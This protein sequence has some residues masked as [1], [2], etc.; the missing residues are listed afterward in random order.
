MCSTL[1][2][3]STMTVRRGA[4]QQG[5]A[6]ESALTPTGDSNLHLYS[7]IFSG[8]PMGVVVLH[9]E[10]PED[11][12]SFRIVS[13]NPA[14]ASLTGCSLDKV[15]G[16]TLGEFP[17]LLKTALPRACMNVLH[18]RHPRNLGEISYGDERIHQG[19]YSVQIF[20]LYE[21]FLAVAFENITVRRQ[22]EQ[23]LIESEERFRLLVQSVQE[24]AIFQLDP[25][26]QI[27]SWNSGAERLKG[28]RAEEV[29]GKQVSLFYPPEDVQSGKPA[30]LLAEAA[31]RGQSEDEGWR[32]RKDGSRFWAYVAVTALRNTKGI[33]QGFAKVTRDMT[34]WRGKE[35][36]LEKAKELLEL[37]VRQ[38][39]AVLA[40]LNAELR[41]E[42]AERA[43]AEEQLKDSLEQLRSLAARIQS[44]REEERTSIARE[45][46]DELGQSC[47]AL[48]MDLA[49]IGLK[50]T[51]NQ[52]PLR[53]KIDSALR[54]VDEMIGTLR[55]IASDLRPRTL[56]DLG[57]NAALEWQAQEFEGRT[58]IRCR[59]TFLGKPLALD[60]E[61][62]TA[63]FRI[64]QESLTNVVRHA[65]ATRVEARLE[66]QL[67]YLLFQV[68][69][70][71]S[72]FDP[73][74]PRSHRSLGLV[75]MQ[76]RA[77][78][79]NGELKIEGIPGSG[80]T[81]TLR[82]PLPRFSTPPVDTK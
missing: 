78:L 75:G 59:V 31:Q 50:L 1:Y 4:G 56:D 20:P 21:N 19:I 37:R 9:L 80:T 70:N 14:V 33:L 26:G 54:L 35:E 39:T 43:R 29:V 18:G 41:T 8:L 24:Y 34:E 46:H 2:G 51:K 36:T 74:Q 11:P 60:S 65:H 81:L 71:G 77:L 67:D 76:E 25:L 68:H 64:F 38:R 57:L 30:R 63:I 72:G 27:V 42:I 15:R 49:L 45:I 23:A 73:K 17:G 13:L 79:L 82:I 3:Q 10:I 7:E 53:A 40:Q 61:R 66:R 48:K 6:A 22:S 55:R 44:V 16:R 62:A 5:R 32:V 12:S 47:T 28:Y 52:R 69:D 58:G